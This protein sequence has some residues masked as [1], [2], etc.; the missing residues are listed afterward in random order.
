MILDM[1]PTNCHPSDT[2]RL[3]TSTE[4]G[5]VDSACRIYGLKGLRVVCAVLDCLPRHHWMSTF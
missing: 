4:D 1:G 2:C 5:V 3:S